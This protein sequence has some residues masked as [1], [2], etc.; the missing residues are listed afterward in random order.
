MAPPHERFS[1]TIMAMTCWLDILNILDEW[2]YVPAFNKQR[3]PLGLQ[4]LMR[5]SCACRGLAQRQLLE[6]TPDWYQQLRDDARVTIH[7]IPCANQ[8]GS[9]VRDNVVFWR[10]DRLHTM[11]VRWHLDRCTHGKRCQD[12]KQL[13]NSFHPH[14]CT[15]RVVER[16]RR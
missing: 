8:L 15:E 12:S 7:V 3:L 13:A 16:A 2:F 9:A 14:T 11:Y 10:L 1:Q 4:E 5:L 6:D